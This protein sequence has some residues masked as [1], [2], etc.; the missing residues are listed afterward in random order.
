MLR[1]RIDRIASEAGAETVAVSLYDYA[2]ETAWSLRGAR[3]FH[4]A[5]TIKVAVLFALYEAFDRGDLPSDGALH[6]RN[7]FLSVVDG[8]PFTVDASR[9]A[10]SEVFARR[11]KTMPLGELAE[12]MIQTSSNLA[13]NLLVDLLGAERI[14]RVL[15]D[16]DVPGVTI[17][18]GVEDERA[19]E[20]GL[21]NEVTA[22]GLVRLFR[23]IHDGTL[24]EES[25]RAMRATLLGQR[26][27]SGI[28]GGLPDDVRSEAEIAH[29][30]GEI[31]TVA[32][33]AG[34]VSLSDRKPY[35]LAILTEWP[36]DASADRRKTLA[37]ISAA[38]YESLAGSDD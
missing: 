32:H 4:A 2:S 9:D 30:T 1:S 18:R 29:K 35:V 24:S 19:W 37:E 17:V 8:A 20:A 16:H 25:T 12:H 26:F 33:D 6:I 36:S 21:N 27:R 38:I 11:G 10:N 34:I 28:P 7:R 15:H 14:Q 23:V 5:S 13:T 22:D 31:S 3:A